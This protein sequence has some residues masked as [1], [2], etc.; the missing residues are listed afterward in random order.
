MAFLTFED[1][2]FVSRCEILRCRPTVASSP[3][4]ASDCGS[5]STTSVRSPLANAAEAS[6][7]ETVVLPTPPLRELK[8]ITRIISTL[9]FSKVEL[10]T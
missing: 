10:R 3:V 8:L 9:A 2:G 7:R 5:I 6:P 1:R 4:E